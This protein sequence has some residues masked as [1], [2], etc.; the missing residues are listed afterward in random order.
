MAPD[1]TRPASSPRW[2]YDSPPD[3]PLGCILINVSCSSPDVSGVR[4]S[5]HT[6]FVV[7]RRI[8]RDCALTIRPISAVGGGLL[9]SKKNPVGTSRAPLICR[10]ER[11]DG[12]TRPLSTW[13][14]IPIDRRAFFPRSWSK[15]AFASRSERI[16]NPSH[17]LAL[18]SLPATDFL[19]TAGGFSPELLAFREFGS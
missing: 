19:G 9:C 10:N 8:L 13:L 16:W 4:S 15:S 11:T 18:C 7:S 1:S 12:E 17:R 6:P 3:D 14:N 2:T 5:L